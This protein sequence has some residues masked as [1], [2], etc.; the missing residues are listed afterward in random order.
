MKNHVYTTIITADVN[1]GSSGDSNTGFM[2]F[3]D[4]LIDS[5]CF[6]VIRD[7]YTGSRIQQQQQKKRGGIKNKLVVVPSFVAIQFTKF[8][9]I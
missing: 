4:V 3:K 1:R 9:I 7:V 8:K 6:V 5:F 2:S